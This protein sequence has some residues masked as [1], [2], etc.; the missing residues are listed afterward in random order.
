MTLRR[1]SREKK[2]TVA[3]I[4]QH[5]RGDERVASVLRAARAVVGDH[6]RKLLKPSRLLVDYAA[7]GD[8]EKLVRELKD[9]ADPDSRDNLGTSALEA[10]AVNC[11]AEALERLLDYK[12][13]VP[14]ELLTKLDRVKMQN[15]PEI[16]ASLQDA[17]LSTIKCVEDASWTAGQGPWSRGLIPTE[18]LGEGAQFRKNPT[19]ARLKSV[20]T[21]L[22]GVVTNVQR[23]A[24]AGV[25]FEFDVRDDCAGVL[26]FH[27]DRA[28]AEYR[29]ATA[30]L[31]AELAARGFERTTYHTLTSD[32][33]AAADAA[34]ADI[35][36]LP[37][38]GRR[39]LKFS[40]VGATEFCLLLFSESLRT[41]C[42]A[43]V[44]QG[45]KDW[46]LGPLPM[47]ELVDGVEHFTDRDYCFDHV[48]DVLRGCAMTKN[49]C[50]CF[51][52]LEIKISAYNED[53]GVLIAE[54]WVNPPE[55][56]NFH[57]AQVFSITCKPFVKLLGDLG[58]TGPT[59][60]EKMTSPSQDIP[61][62][63]LWRKPIRGK[64]SVT[65]RLEG[66]MEIQIVALPLSGK[67]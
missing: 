47:V 17:G 57:W 8:E 63:N 19:V 7:N 54:S 22:S 41:T 21:T 64:G 53:V 42:V 65:I 15:H 3:R 37:V 28:R 43:E 30:A 1:T 50:H 34:G 45:N 60:F 32:A 62:V 5:E 2:R 4:L 26:V 40:V 44:T 12:A 51:D 31:E 56:E 14:R 33:F 6:L 20:P 58:F 9:Y 35:W 46:A 27:A 48:P 29:D 13:A 24:G 18:K 36:R 10:A 67:A 39:V 25:F 16:L 52:G 61:G 55:G 49:P 23:P 66:D 38:A 11:Q 59:L